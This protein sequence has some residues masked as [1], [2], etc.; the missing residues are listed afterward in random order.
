MTQRNKYDATLIFSPFMES[1]QPHLAVP[2]LTSYLQA[3]GYNIMYADFNLDFWH[4]CCTKEFL[5]FLYRMFITK[6]N[7]LKKG[8]LD[9]GNYDYYIE[10]VLALIA[11]K[12]LLRTKNFPCSNAD[13]PP[14]S[15]KIFA[16][17]GGLGFHTLYNND[18]KDFLDD[19][20]VFLGSTDLPRDSRV[21]VRSASTISQQISD[22]EISDKDKNLY[23]SIYKEFFLKEFKGLET[24]LV[25]ISIAMNEQVIPALSLACSI[26]SIDKDIHVCLGGSYISHIDKFT[27]E[28]ILHMPFI[29]SM[30]LYE[31]EKPL[32]LLIESIKSGKELSAVPNLAYLGKDGV[33]V[34]PVCE[35]VN[36]DEI[37]PPNY[38]CIT[39]FFPD[40]LALSVYS[41][42]GCYWGKCVY[43][44]YISTTG[45]PKRLQN[46]SP[47]ILVNEIAFLQRKYGVR[48]FNLI[49]EAVAPSYAGKIADL[50]L[51]RDLKINLS[52]WIRVEKQ[53]TPELCS[54]LS[55]AGF[56]F[57]TI[58]VESLSDRVL[59]KMGKGYTGDDAIRIIRDVSEAGINLQI[60]IIVG[61]PTE[62]KEEALETYK[63]LEREISS[64]TNVFVSIFPFVLFNNARIYNSPH[65]FGLTV[66]ENKAR[67]GYFFPKNIFVKYKKNKGMPIKDV[68]NIVENY[69]TKFGKSDGSH[70]DNRYFQPAQNAIYYSENVESHFI[71]YHFNS[72]KKRL[73]RSPKYL[74]FDFKCSKVTI[75]DTDPL[76][77][78]QGQPI[79]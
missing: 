26:K 28:K 46:K 15:K 35:P 9:A 79:L 53:F 63:R 55:S 21:F 2:H 65:E 47:E 67:D 78:I 75:S 59:K 37:P 42:R 49:N 10:K 6:I 13:F 45:N 18:Y 71:D 14:F 36:L 72:D 11:V 73:E 39:P 66:L 43:C 5:E 12:N 22:K 30:V 4:L 16:L 3:H 31:G 33:L 38:D 20:I 19:L 56:N 70:F 62:T 1:P 50:L 40:E 61:F 54:K 29:D 7:H 48:H 23:L 17:V 60:N 51:E 77:Q 8:G 41:S 32:R 25:G 58:G 68:F 57:L 52:S 64:K 76:Y 44:N 34:N 74:L 69:T 24:P 27:M